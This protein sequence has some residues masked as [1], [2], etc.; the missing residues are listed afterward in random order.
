MGA[1]IVHE[2][3]ENAHQNT[4]FHLKDADIERSLEEDNFLRSGVI[5]R[6]FVRNM[7]IVIY[8]DDMINASDLTVRLTTFLRNIRLLVS[9]NCHQ[10]K[11]H[12]E[13]NFGGW[14]DIM[15]GVSEEELRMYTYPSDQSEPTAQKVRKGMMQNYLFKTVM[16]TIISVLNELQAKGHTVK[17]NNPDSDWKFVMTGLPG[18]VNDLVES[19]S[20]HRKVSKPESTERQ[21]LTCTVEVRRVGANLENVLV[22]LYNLS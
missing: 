4:K 3:P 1:A 17:L 12:I 16:E 10:A 6:N 11:I 22:W 21:K 2:L 14:T 15:N 8:K 9:L 18:V 5:P 20:A 7:V 13:M 19:R